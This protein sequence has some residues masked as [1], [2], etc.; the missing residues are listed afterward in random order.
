MATPQTNYNLSHQRDNDGRKTMDKLIRKTM[1]QCR[2][3]KLKPPS[4]LQD[5]SVEERS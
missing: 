1:M 5:G 3:T 4:R 2:C